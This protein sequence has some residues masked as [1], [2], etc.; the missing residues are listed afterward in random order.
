MFLK[1]SAYLQASI[2]LFIW[3]RVAGPTHYLSQ[4]ASC[5]ISSFPII[6]TVD[7][8]CSLA[9]EPVCPPHLLNLFFLISSNLF[10]CLLWLN[11][12][13]WLTCQLCRFRCNSATAYVLHNFS[14]VLADWYL[15]LY[16]DWVSARFFSRCI[17]SLA[18][19]KKTGKKPAKNVPPNSVRN[20]RPCTLSREN[21][22]F[23]TSITPSE[24][25][26]DSY[27]LKS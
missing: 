26:H 19:E 3:T 2:Q 21:A 20:I 13:Y 17:F 15:W 8:F 23:A 10:P 22:I 14:N 27:K 1:I 9:R 11:F 12:V 25:S 18:E 4:L 24:K 6:Q 5:P 7:I 16:I